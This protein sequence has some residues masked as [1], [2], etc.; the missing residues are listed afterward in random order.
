[1]GIELLSSIFQLAIPSVEPH[2]G[3]LT[4]Q[5]GEEVQVAI[6]VQGAQDNGITLLPA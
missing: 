5:A 1:V 6:I 2:A 3:I 4:E